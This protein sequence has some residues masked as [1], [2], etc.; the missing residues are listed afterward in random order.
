MNG[1]ASIRPAQLRCEYRENPLGIDTDTP[2]LSWVPDSDKRGQNQTAYHV[3]VASAPEILATDQGNL[4]D[5]TKVASNETI[6]IHYRGSRL[7]LGQQCWWKVRVW[8]QADRISEWSEINSWTMGL[9][10]A[11]GSGAHWIGP[12]PNKAAMAD[13]PDRSECPPESWFKWKAGLAASGEKP[14]PLPLLRREFDAATPVRRALVSVCGLGHYELRLN[15]EKVGDHLFDPGWTDYRK[16]CLYSTYDVTGQIRVGKNCLGA[17]LGNGMFHERGWRYYKFVGSF[18]SPQMILRLRLE[19]TDGT[20]ADLVSDAAWRVAPGP[21]TFSSIF[22]GEDYDARLEQPGWDRPGFDDT[23][24][25]PVTLVESPGGQLRAQSAPPIKVMETFSPIAITEPKPGVFVYDLGQNFSGR[26]RIRLKG[27][28]GTHVRITPAE[29]LDA[30]GLADQQGWGCPPG[31]RTCL[32]YFDYTLKGD[33]I[34]SWAPRFTYYGFRYLQ[35]EGAVPN[36]R[37]DG[38]SPVVV[39]LEGEFT[40]NSA[41]RAGSF[42]CSDELLNGIHRLVDWALASN[43]Q[44]VVTDCPHREKLQ[45]LEIAHLTAPSIMYTYDVP[46]LYAKITRDIADAQLPNGLVPTTAPEYSVFS[47]MFRDSPEWG[48]ASVIIPW[49]LYRWYGDTRILAERYLTM[50]RYVDYLTSRA[51]DHII[52]HGLGD[53]G[54]IPN[55]KDHQGWAQMTPL[56]ITGTGIYYYD[57]TILART[58]AILNKRDE[59]E[60]Y[61][62]LAENIR[63]DFNRMLFNPKTNQYAGGTP[64]APHELRH[65]YNRGLFDPE[66]NEYRGASQVSQAIPLALGLVDPDRA[67]AVFENL[68]LDLQKQEYTTAGDVGHRFLLQALAER[69]RSD[70]IYKL[71]RRTSNPGYGWQ[72]KRG[73]TALGECWDGRA[74]ATMNH[75]MLGH[76]QEWF[77]AHILGIQPAPEAVAFDKIVIR[78]QIVGDITWARGH[79]DSIRGKI[80]VD[81]RIEADQFIL[82]VTIPANTSATIHIPARNQNTIVHHVESGNYDFTVP[83]EKE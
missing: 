55:V 5:S 58:A 62:T 43:L 27:P 79:Y 51:H 70:L 46:A 71:H 57:V 49:L 63:R 28:D 18:G 11:S 50:K 22:G 77:H 72:I 34:E 45:W 80:A 16:T 12:V 39:T 65:D 36:D 42:A 10:D 4:W 37:S 53:W 83:F 74:C 78:P 59:A 17:M 2:R 67:D 24:W 19:F 38:T 7:G 23:A 64:A 81:W 13:N 1:C 44:S 69:G 61:R 3:L 60:R 15:G 6:Q 73:L 66:T 75:G 40:R 25:K 82:H 31:E 20:T 41:A 29:G 35:V 33:S 30:N 68:L 48:S 9:F 56:S 54:D 52:S 21:I 8:D 14:D 47:E 26:P 32:T 76:I